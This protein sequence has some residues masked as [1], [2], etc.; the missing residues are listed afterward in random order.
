LIQAW[1][2]VGYE[3]DRKNPARA[4]LIKFARVAQHKALMPSLEISSRRF[5]AR[6][7]RPPSKMAIEEKLANPH[8]AKITMA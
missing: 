5:G 6:A 1:L 4:A 8:S 2:E 3:K 7:P